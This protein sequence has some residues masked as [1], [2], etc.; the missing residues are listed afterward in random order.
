MK[1]FSPT[2]YAVISQAHIL[3]QSCARFTQDTTVTDLRRML[4]MMIS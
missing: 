2:K 3:D 1:N 4:G